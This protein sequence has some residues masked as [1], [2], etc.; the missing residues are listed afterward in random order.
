MN[1]KTYIFLFFLFITGLSVAQEGVKIKDASG[2]GGLPPDNNAV[3]ELNSATRG[4]LL[5]RLVLTSIHLPAPLL[6]HV[7]GMLVYNVSSQHGVDVGLYFNDGNKWIKTNST[8]QLWVNTTNNT[9]DYVNSNG[10]SS[11]VDISPLLKEPWHNIENRQQATSNTQN[12]YQMGRVGI[13][14]NTPDASSQL[15]VSS[16]NKGILIPR[17]SETERN[18]IT[19]PAVGLLIFNT[20]EGC[21][22]YWKGA[23]WKSICGGDGPAD[24]TISEA[25]CTAALVQGAPYLQGETLG[26][27]A[28]LIIALA[29]TGP[30]SYIIEGTT[31]N[32]YFF[33]ASGS[34]PATGNYTLTLP[35]TGAP[36]NPAPAPGND[37]IISINGTPSGCVKKAIVNPA[38]IEFAINCGSAVVHGTY[39]QGTVTGSSNTI[40]L[41]VNVTYGGNSV[42]STNTV[43]GISFS[44]GPVTLSPGLQNITLH[45]SG[46]PTSSGAFSYTINGIGS[47]AACPVNVTVVPAPVTY[48]MTC[49]SVSTAGNYEVG[50]VTDATNTMTIPVN[51]IY[52]GNWNVSTNVVNGIKW[53]GSG[54]FSTTGNQ[55]IVLTASGTPVDAG[56]FTYT[57]TSNSSSGVI[58]CSKNQVSAYRKMRVL[59]LGTGIAYVPD[60]SNATYSASIIPKTAANFG[61]LS[62]STVKSYGLDVIARNANTGTALKNFINSNNIDIIILGYDYNGT[63]AATLQVLYDFVHH[64]KGVLI[65]MCQTGSRVQAYINKIFD[66]TTTATVG[67]SVLLNPSVGAAHPIANGPFGNISAGTFIGGDV[68]DNVYITSATLPPNATVLATKNGNTDH[69][70]SIVH[71]TL[72]FTWTGDGGSI[73][74]TASNT[75]PN[76]YPCMVDASGIPIPKVYNGANVHN[77]KWYANTLSWAIKYV[78]SNTDS[79]YVIP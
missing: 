78:H 1:I 8:S 62:S 53:S 21:F 40:T 66:V 69:L 23:A 39:T 44:S 74:G 38:P 31:T 36:Q 73:A 55:N 12:I 72:G 11:S 67:S 20:T 76:L 59:G 65:Y 18:N 41:P 61:T 58:T 15:D 43:N 71:N 34:F 32:G 68:N 13:N 54:T 45:A 77:S 9:L 52:P 14:T 17:M 48:A 64:K 42:I 50:K 6:N 51:V 35:A 47:T 46:T 37:I 22:N 75:D 49:A 30:G 19:A 57:I 29:V 56:D 4:L 3:L 27:G 70:F 7:P 63:D 26:S 2:T 10:D 60:P 25:S 79:N 33:S 16:F 24:I 28:H 5:P